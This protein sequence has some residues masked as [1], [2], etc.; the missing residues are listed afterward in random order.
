MRT[1]RSKLTALL[2]VIVAAGFPLD[3]AHASGFARES[4]ANCAHLH[5]SATPRVNAQTAPYE[6]IN[7]R[8]SSCAANDQTITLSQHRSGSFAP[9][10]TSNRTWTITLLPG[11]SETEIQHIG[12]TCCGSYIVS[13]KVLSAGRVLTHSHT[14]FTFA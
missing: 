6:T 3:Q 10:G 9:M 13:D 12:Y 4:V 8:V 1:A 5:V 2:V 14:S 11:Q 7:N